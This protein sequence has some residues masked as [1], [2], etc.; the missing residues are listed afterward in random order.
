MYE[1]KMVFPHR[2]KIKYNLNQNTM[3]LGFLIREGVG[4]QQFEIAW[5]RSGLYYL[6]VTIYCKCIKLILTSRYATVTRI[7]S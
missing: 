7:V 3:S 6:Q 2:F 4:V 5:T 1:N